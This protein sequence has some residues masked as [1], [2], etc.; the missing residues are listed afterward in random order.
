MFIKR[1]L[2]LSNSSA[3]KASQKNFSIQSEH[4]G[5]SDDDDAPTVAK[6]IS[7]NDEQNDNSV[8]ID[9]PIS[10]ST[11]HTQKA[12]DSI[13]NSTSNIQSAVT[14]PIKRAPVKS[15]RNSQNASSSTDH[16]RIKCPACSNGD[17][18]A[19]AHKCIVCDKAVHPFDGCSVSIGDEEGYGEQRKC[20]AC[21]QAEAVETRSK[22]NQVL[23]AKDMNHE[24]KWQR[25]SK[26]NTSKYTQ[27]VKN[28]NLIA[29]NKKVQIGCLVNENL[30][31]IVY[32]NGPKKFKLSNTCA[33]D[34]AIQLI[35]T[36][37]AYN[38]VYRTSVIHEKDG[39]FEIAKALAAK[40][41]FY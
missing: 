2:Q 17:S 35:A 36:A 39:I 13:V 37:I 22:E 7:P 1:D 25:T 26:S 8:D 10:S 21:H 9:T 40:Y 4:L 27:S 34:A 30:K 31:Q 28:W 6:N 5:F 29:I 24:E 20:I 41:G 23:D 16:D 14:E 18:P 32:K 11:S 19:G 15:T 33:I 38:S 12:V 3:I